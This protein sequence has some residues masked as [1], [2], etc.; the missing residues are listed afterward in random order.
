[1]FNFF[2]DLKKE[3]SLKNEIVS[4]FNVVMMSGKFVYIE[5]QKGL[6]KLSSENVSVKV[7]GGVV[8]VLGKDLKISEMTGKTLAVSGSIS[9]VEVL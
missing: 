4:D 3:Y 7:K 2:N 5:G 6:L 8:C 1:M 9:S